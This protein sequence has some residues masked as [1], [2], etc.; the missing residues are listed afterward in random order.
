MEMSLQRLNILILFL[1]FVLLFADCGNKKPPV[2]PSELLGAPGS[3]TL[4][5]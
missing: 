1:V 5:R 3:T 4:I 2:P